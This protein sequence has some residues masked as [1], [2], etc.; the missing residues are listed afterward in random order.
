M[1]NLMI[2]G[3]DPH[4]SV[5]GGRGCYVYTYPHVRMCTH[6]ILPFDSSYAVHMPASI[7]VHR[8]LSMWQFV[9][10]CLTKLSTP[11]PCHRLRIGWDD[12]R[13]ALQATCLDFEMC[14]YAALFC[15]GLKCVND[16][17]LC[18]CVCM[19]TPVLRL[20]LRLYMR[21]YVVPCV[22]VWACPGLYTQAHNC[23]YI[24][25]RIYICVCVHLK[26]YKLICVCL[27]ARAHVHM[28]IIWSPG[29]LIL[30]SICDG[31]MQ[32]LD[33]RFTWA[34]RC[35]AARHISAVCTSIPAEIPRYA[36]HW[37]KSMTQMC[38]E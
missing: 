1:I 5:P 15:G 2:Q 34:L 28:K 22:Y 13:L 24:S 27:C 9:C 32:N 30:L 38:T 37:V 6:V 25:R 23:M 18:S 26:A 20:H 4:L 29:Q 7:W 3:Q 19:W 35:G 33:E 21:M 17:W 36:W 16:V 10:R 12:F 11:F 31:S 14:F 8:H